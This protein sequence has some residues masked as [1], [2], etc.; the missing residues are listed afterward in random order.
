MINLNHWNRVY[1]EF[2]KKKYVRRI[3]IRWTTLYDIIQM[4]STMI[5]CLTQN[6]EVCWASGER[7]PLRTSPLPGQLYSP[8]S[9]AA[10]THSETG[11]HSCLCSCSRR[12]TRNWWG[13]EHQAH[14]YALWCTQ[15]SQGQRIHEY[16]CT[17]RGRE[18]VWERDSTLKREV[19]AI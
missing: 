3:W 14:G 19:T 17:E 13:C 1:R 10:N 9:S 15:R 7:S 12:G 18:C 2:E 5:S 8:G 6:V 11:W 4:Y 16:W